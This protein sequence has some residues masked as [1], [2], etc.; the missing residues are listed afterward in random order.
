MTGLILHFESGHTIAWDI[1]LISI[2]NKSWH[3]FILVMGLPGSGKSCF[4]RQLASVTGA[5]Y[6]SSD[7]VR[8]VML[9]V[10]T[11]SDKE[12][13]MV[14]DEM[15]RM[16]VTA[17][18]EGR[19]VVLDATFYTQALRRAFTRALEQ[20][21]RIILIEVMADERLIRERLRRPR[22]DSDANFEVYAELKELWEPVP[23]PHLT[24]RSTNE[25]VES[26]LDQAMEYIHQAAYEQGTD[27]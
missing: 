18:G 19:N 7:Q 20:A 25:N 2:C 27:R 22:M 17:A 11:Y 24:L 13:W 16:A 14:Y 10:A 8:Q 12:K 15:L 1:L 21:G 5:E 23:E 26:L 4:A 3:M 9:G 6:I